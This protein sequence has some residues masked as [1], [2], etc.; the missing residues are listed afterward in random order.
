MLV[1]EIISATLEG[2][3]SRYILKEP[4]VQSHF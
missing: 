2:A 3:I 4:Y 1:E